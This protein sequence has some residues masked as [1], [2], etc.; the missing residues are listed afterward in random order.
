MVA[1][2]EIGLLI[3]EI[4]YNNTDYVSESGFLTAIWAILLNTIVSP[5][6]VGL[7]VK[8]KGAEIGGDAWGLVPGPNMRADEDEEKGNVSEHTV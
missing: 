8:F 7:L 3:V 5:M 2:D 6:V 4:G 1:R